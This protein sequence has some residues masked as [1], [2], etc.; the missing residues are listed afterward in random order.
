MQEIKMLIRLEAKRNRWKMLQKR[1]VYTK[2]TG[3]TSK[4]TK[5]K[6]KSPKTKQTLNRNSKDEKENKNNKKT[7]YK[8]H[9]TRKNK[10]P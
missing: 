10:I 6:I 8:I 2:L 9:I 5:V 7:E 1:L 3:R 4:K